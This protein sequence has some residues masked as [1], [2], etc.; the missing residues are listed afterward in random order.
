M[1]LLA[2]VASSLTGFTFSDSKA[3]SDYLVGTWQAEDG[4]PQ[5]TV[6]CIAQTRDGYLWVGTSN[7]LARIDG[8]RFVTFRSADTPGLRSNRIRCLYEDLRGVLWIGTEVAG[9]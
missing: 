4:L 8:V 5:N 1:F 6:N 9:W 2:A 7:G 3:S